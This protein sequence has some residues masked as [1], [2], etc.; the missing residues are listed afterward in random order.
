M[1]YAQQITLCCNACVKWHVMFLIKICIS[2]ILRLS[3][4][5]FKKVLLQ[6]CR[7]YSAKQQEFISCA[8][9]NECTSDL[10]IL[11]KVYSRFICCAHFHV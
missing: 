7:S 11:L 3:V 9:N 6:N 5:H 8:Q 10:S 1:G 2:D 4:G